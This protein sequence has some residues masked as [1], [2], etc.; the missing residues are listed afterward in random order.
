MQQLHHVEPEVA[1][2]RAEH[3][4]TGVGSRSVAWHHGR[5]SMTGWQAAL[6]GA[7]GGLA[8]EALEFG[9]VIRRTGRWPWRMKGEPSASIFAVSV[10]I[11]VG[12]GFGL[13]AAAA[14]TNQIAG[15]IAAIAIGVAAPL[16][17][18]KMSARA[19]VSHD[20]P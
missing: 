10:L 1:Y 2:R 6:W 16:I 20:D 13:A 3:A 17:I 11:R 14:E 4:A 5:G 18:E 8:V 19:E 15:P 7:F 12:V 9:A